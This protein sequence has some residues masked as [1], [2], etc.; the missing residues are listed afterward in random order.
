[1]QNLLAI[2]TA[3]LNAEN[4]KNLFKLKE[5]KRLKMNV[6]NAN[7]RKFAYSFELGKV[8][9]EAVQNYE[10]EQ[11]K[12]LMAESGI[13]WKKEEFYEKAF[14]FKKSNACRLIKFAGLG[15]EKVQEFNAFVDSARAEGKHVSRGVKE[16]LAWAKGE[17]ILGAEEGEEG[18]EA[19]AK[20][21]FTMSFRRADVDGGKNISVRV[22][23]D[24]SVEGST[25]E[26]I[27]FAIA[28]LQSKLA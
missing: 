8:M 3:F 13:S 28:Y 15:E 25:K 2:E 11:G 18:A 5:V 4:T 14:G 9:A 16:C 12:Q 19:E 10:S 1:M 23:A 21:V 24:G 27:E 26:E 7:D 17:D 20:C 6:D 22:K